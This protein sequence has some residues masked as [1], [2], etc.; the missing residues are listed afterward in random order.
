MMVNAYVVASGRIGDTSA[1]PEGVRLLLL[2]DHGWSGLCARGEGEFVALRVTSH[3]GRT[4]RPTSRF[5]L[6]I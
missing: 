5:E 3:P 1:E 4:V 6:G 2:H